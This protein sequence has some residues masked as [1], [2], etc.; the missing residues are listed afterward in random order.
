MTNGI[1][2]AYAFSA[3]FGQSVF[4]AL[5][6]SFVVPCPQIYPDYICAAFATLAAIFIAA[7]VVGRGIRSQRDEENIPIVK[8]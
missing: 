5:V 7:A 4:P 8:R 1:G 6:G 3:M 2:A